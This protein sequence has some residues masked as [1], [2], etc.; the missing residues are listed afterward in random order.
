MVGSVV[1]GEPRLNSSERR[2]SCLVGD[3]IGG[4]LVS[5]ILKEEK[6]RVGARRRERV[7]GKGGDFMDLGKVMMV[8]RERDEQSR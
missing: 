6:E 5:D 1:K 4:G 2:V 7:K 3:G 8:E